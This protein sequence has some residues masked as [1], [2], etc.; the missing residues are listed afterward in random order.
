MEMVL[1]VSEYIR[2]DV[3][4]GNS[5]RRKLV[6]KEYS[7]GGKPSLGAFNTCAVYLISLCFFFCLVA[8]VVCGQRKCTVL[9]YMAS[10]V[11]TS[12]EKQVCRWQTTLTR[13]PLQKFRSVFA[14]GQ[15][16]CKAP[17]RIEIAVHRKKCCQGRKGTERR[18]HNPSD[19]V[20]RKTQGFGGLTLL[21]FSSSLEKLSASLSPHIS[22][23]VGYKP[24]KIVMSI[25]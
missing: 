21:S 25:K 4:K 14:K 13:K 5:K 22:K 20:W 8:Q 23:A 24:C 16:Y 17:Q 11:V 10:P 6:L 7:P 15:I 1:N 12:A 3:C 9:S 19:M 18:P 2:C